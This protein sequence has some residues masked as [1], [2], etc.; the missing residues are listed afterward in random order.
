MKKILDYF[1]IITICLL[2][3]G[4]CNLYSYYK[5]FN[6]DIYN[7]INNTEIL[8]S[9][10]PTI[11]LSV[12][13]IYSFVYQKMLDKVQAF[14]KSNSDDDDLVRFDTGTDRVAE[15]KEIS[16]PIKKKKNRFLKA[17]RSLPI[18]IAL[19]YIVEFSINL[20]LLNVFKFKEYDLQGINLLYA[21]IFSCVIYFGSDLLTN[22][23]RLNENMM[24]IS[25][26][27]VLYIGSQINTYRRFD[28][29]KIKDG[30]AIKELAFLYNNK[31]VSTSKTQI[32]IGQTQS[33]LFLFDRKNK[34]TIVYKL[35]NIDSL[36][37][38]TA[39]NLR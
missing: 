22:E 29:L 8:L 11:V 25:V 18:L 13:L 20:L 26:F 14:A 28:A 35:E 27:T 3:F 10:L 30:I 1:P 5:E 7:Y 31:Q 38:K 17:L 4:F 34:T 36:I 21:F 37:I 15:E 39:T 19:L 2:Y 33:N 16:N 23:S 12:T 32:F 24:L 6:L 9:F